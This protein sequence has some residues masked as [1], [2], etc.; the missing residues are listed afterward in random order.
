LLPLFVCWAAVWGASWLLPTTYQSEAL[1][2]VD[3]QKV[4]DKFVQPNVNVDL[5]DRL[6]SITQQILSRTRLQG[7][8]DHFQL[9]SRPHGL[10]AL[11]ESSDPIDQMLKDI[12]IDLV[13]SPGRRGEFSAF[14]IRYSAGSPQ[15]AQQVNTELASL[16]VGENER[17]DRTLSEDTTT[18]LENQLA[19]A[20]AKMEEQEAAVAA[21][22][23]KHSGDL[24][25]QLESNVQ[26]LAG[27]QGQLQNT[28][29]ALDVSKQQR[30][31]L[32]SM[33]QQ[34][35]SASA[36]LGGGDSTMTEPQTLDKQLLD[37]HL[38][39][40]DLRSR[41][42]DDYPDVLA[43]KDM[44]EKTETL[45]KQTE[46]EWVSNQGRASASSALDVH[47]IGEAPRDSRAATMQIASQLKAN[48]LEIQSDQLREKD[49]ESQISAYQVRLNMTPETEQKLADVS[50]GYDES[51]SNYD[52][53]LQKQ[54]QSQL[55]TS[56]EQQQQGEQFRILDPPSLPNKPS[57]PNHFR[58]SLGGLGLGIV[59]GMALA[60]LLE[61][62]DIRVYQEKDLQG[63]VPV[64]VLV[65][66]PRLS[67]FQED[68]SR[69]TK[70]W[71]QL[72]ALAAMAL[73]IVI[74]NLY[75]FYKG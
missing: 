45:K 23:T 29:H 13:E 8:I 55:A 12:K 9:Y 49:L 18:F 43:L 50:R 38:R 28:Q 58:I 14:K 51:K 25:G 47:A 5:Q 57:A 22:K 60:A 48:Q 32:E 56:L 74:G 17:T 67:T 35:Q 59:V 24:P 72:G 62:T 6:Q 37:M 30:I 31:Y 44:I 40:E 33:L 64:R 20:R 41:Y 1:I 3:Q 15:L 34:F 11:S 10:G 26:I 73:T 65:G 66:I 53:L 19:D 46:T 71:I 70:R 27:L 54:M 42:T 69:L 7:M 2:L 39:L 52:S 21:F 16:F 61:L 4:P 75:S 36:S 63:I 68:H